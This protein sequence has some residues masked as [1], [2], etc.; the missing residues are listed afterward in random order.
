MILWGNLTDTEI[1]ILSE[2]ISELVTVSEFDPFVKTR[3]LKY[4]II[5]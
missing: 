4:T 1:S 2:N 5:K 3:I